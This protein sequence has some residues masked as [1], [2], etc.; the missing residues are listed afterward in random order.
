MEWQ[1]GPP[2]NE[3]IVEVE[4]DG[5]IIEVMAFYGRD[6]SQ[7]HWRTENGDKAWSVETFKRWRHKSL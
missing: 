2:P 7:P 1:T 5:E 6:G 4:S 3:K